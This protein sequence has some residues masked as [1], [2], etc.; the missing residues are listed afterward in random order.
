[1]TNKRGTKYEDFEAALLRKPEIRRE[2]EVLKPKYKM[3]QSLIE[4]RNQLRIS[5]T[6]LARIIGTRQPAISR[7][8][9]GDYNT[10][11]N[12]LFKVASALDL[13]ISLKAGR[14]TKLAYDKVH[15]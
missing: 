14:A 8:E 10:T 2:Y 4:R 12:T 9:R 7:L 3:I 6:Q 5:Q 15:A 1:M 11:L 13:D